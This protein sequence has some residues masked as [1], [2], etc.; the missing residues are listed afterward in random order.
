MANKDRSFHESPEKPGGDGWLYSEQ[1][2][3]LYHFA[4]NNFFAL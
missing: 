2:Q 4:P 3:K 1:Q